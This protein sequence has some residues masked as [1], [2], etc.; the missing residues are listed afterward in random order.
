MCCFV[1]KFVHTCRFFGS[2]CS[3][4]PCLLQRR[5]HTPCTVGRC[6]LTVRTRHPYREVRAVNTN[7]TEMVTIIPT[8]EVSRPVVIKNNRVTSLRHIWKDD[9]LDYNWRK[10]CAITCNRWQLN[11]SLFCSWSFAGGTTTWSGSSTATYSGQM[12]N[13]NCENCVL[14]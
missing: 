9:N 8:A 2:L 6:R 14:T 10:L 4:H 11:Y 13:Y 12:D 7:L 1:T 5:V 3:T